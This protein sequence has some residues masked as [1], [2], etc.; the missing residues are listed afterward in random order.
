MIKSGVKAGGVQ[1]EIL[2]AI[3]EAREIYRDLG[4][5]I[6]IT[7]LTEGKHM[8]GS[9]HAPGKAVDLRTRHLAKADRGIAAQRLRVA[10]GP[11]FDVV[12][13]KTHIHVEWDVK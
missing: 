5:D 9:L 2:L 4:A 12:L 13:E 1:P 7:S 10:L 3:M 11:E 6:I 8:P